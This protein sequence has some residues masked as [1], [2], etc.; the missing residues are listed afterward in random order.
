MIVALGKEEVLA[1]D[2]FQLDAPQKKVK[3]VNATEVR[4]VLSRER[5]FEIFGAVAHP[6]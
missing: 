6:K 3:E 1:E 2:G 5:N 4:D